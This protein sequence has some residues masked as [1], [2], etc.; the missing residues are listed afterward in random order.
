[1]EVLTSPKRHPQVRSPFQKHY[2]NNA[3]KG[4]KCTI[5]GSDTPPNSTIIINNGQTSEK[6]YCENHFSCENCES[7]IPKGSSYIV[8]NNHP[9]CKTC[10]TGKYPK[11]NLCNLPIAGKLFFFHIN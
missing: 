2:A 11:C 10:C 7:T 8:R 1:M 5:C 6:I 9:Y 4:G 3:D